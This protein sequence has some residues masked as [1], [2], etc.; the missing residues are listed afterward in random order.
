MENI[1]LY[2]NVGGNPIPVACW[3]SDP[4]IYPHKTCK[5]VSAQDKPCKNLELVVPG[6]LSGVL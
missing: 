3:L 4:D 1:S 5:Q 2:S 6:I